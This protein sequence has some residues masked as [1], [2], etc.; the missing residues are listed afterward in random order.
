MHGGC[1]DADH[2]PVLDSWAARREPFCVGRQMSS[3]IDTAWM[4][5]FLKSYRTRKKF[6]Y[7]SNPYRSFHTAVPN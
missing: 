7:A 1:T 4:D 6:L 3:D 2:D 5:G